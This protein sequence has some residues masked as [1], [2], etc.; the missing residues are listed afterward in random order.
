MAPGK[1]VGDRATLSDIQK[2]KDTSIEDGKITPAIKAQAMTELIAFR[3]A[4]RQGV[5]ITGHAAAR[6]VFYTMLRVEELVSACKACR[7][8]CLTMATL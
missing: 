5:R 2:A 6:D 4:K 3:L 1:D 7:C 8:K